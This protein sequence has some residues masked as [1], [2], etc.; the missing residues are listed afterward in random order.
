ML[1]AFS[2]MEILIGKEAS[3]RLAGCCVAVFGVG[4]VGSF[5]VEGLARAN[6]GRFVL[7][8]DDFICVTNINRQL[9]ATVETV[10]RPKVEVMRERILAINPSAEVQTCQTFYRAGLVE[11]L[12]R[13]GYDYLID[14]IDTVSSKLDL[15]VRAQELGVPVIS[16]MGA[17]NKL[18]PAGFMAADVYETTVCPLARVMR[19]ELRKRGVKNLKVVYSR[20]EPLRPANSENSEN[21]E[22]SDC[23]YRR[24]CPK[25][26]EEDCG[27]KRRQV[28]GSISF[29]PAAAGLIIAGEVVRDLV[30]SSRIEE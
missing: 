15:V 26:G 17:G 21:S 9:H 5:V 16:C 25:G 1:N 6:I 28:P 14:A 24:Q 29:V 20:E 4:G 13:S 23:A 8:D 10:G 27:A 22:K 19:R 3:A 2:R 7:V 12:V 18:N 11:E 30:Q